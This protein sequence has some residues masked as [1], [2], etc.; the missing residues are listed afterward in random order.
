MTG[1][2]FVRP[3][4]DIYQT[5]KILSQFKPR[6]SVHDGLNVRFKYIILK[7]ISFEKY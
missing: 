5:I 3:E 2:F 1:V 6:S 4:N 7:P